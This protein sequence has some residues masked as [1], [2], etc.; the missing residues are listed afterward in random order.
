MRLSSVLTC[1]HKSILGKYKSEVKPMEQAQIEPQVLEL[2]EVYKKVLEHKPLN[3]E[4]EQLEKVL[5]L[6][7]ELE[8]AEEQAK[9]VFDE[10]ESIKDEIAQKRQRIQELTANIDPRLLYV[11]QLQATVSTLTTPSESNGINK[12]SVLRVLREN[13]DGLGN[14]SICLKLNVT[15]NKQNQNRSYQV[16]KQLEK[17]GLIKTE[18]RL[19]KVI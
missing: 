7:T 18:N 11:K 16:A 9:P 10:I 17:D 2:L 3:I 12:E 14:A 8:E 15:N 4:F 6:K 1:M 13:S 19:W 5:K